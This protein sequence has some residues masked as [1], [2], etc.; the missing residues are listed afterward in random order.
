M[1]TPDI[2]ETSHETPTLTLAAH[3]WMDV[4]NFNNLLLPLIPQNIFMQRLAHPSIEI[5]LFIYTIID[6]LLLFCYRKTLPMLHSK[7]RLENE[8][9][10]DEWSEEEE[11]CI[12]LYLSSFSAH[13]SDSKLIWILFT[14]R[15][16]EQNWLKTAYW[17]FYLLSCLFAHFSGAL[18][19]VVRKM[20]SLHPKLITQKFQKERGF[21][22]YFQFSRQ[23]FENC[24]II[25]IYVGEKFCRSWGMFFVRNATLEWKLLATLTIF[26]SPQKCLK[27][28]NVYKHFAVFETS[29]CA[30]VG[31]LWQTELCFASSQINKSWKQWNLFVEDESVCAWIVEL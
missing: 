7:R 10:R 11:M 21:F 23:A 5:P 2:D 14:R 30:F 22:H 4:G 12:R 15:K 26:T 3:T 8:S 28:L 24:W 31:I 6:F 25:K 16:Q 1:I 17:D 13:A 19:S 27:R 18:A 29:V 9:W 20:M